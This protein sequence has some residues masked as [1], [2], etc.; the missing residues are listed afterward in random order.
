MEQARNVVRDKMIAMCFIKS[1]NKKKYGKLI[2]HLRYQ[3]T[4]LQDV[5]PSSLDEAMEVLDNHITSKYNT[6][7][8]KTETEG[9]KMTINMPKGA[10]HHPETPTISRMISLLGL[11]E[12]PM[13]E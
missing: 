5:Y 6:H 3:A 10:L 4:L 12:E 7:H 11:M 1:S 2:S 13:I 8:E 9:L